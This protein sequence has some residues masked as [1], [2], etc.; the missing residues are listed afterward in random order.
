MC[1][2]ATTVKY[3]FLIIP[4]YRLLI[5]IDMSFIDTYPNPE[6]RLTKFQKLFI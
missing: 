2:T 3:D 4:Y 1:Y 5:N 6:F